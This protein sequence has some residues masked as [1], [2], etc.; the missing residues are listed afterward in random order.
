MADT[1]RNRTTIEEIFKD[2]ISGD[3][4]PQDLR[5]YVATIYDYGRPV[6]LQD[7]KL[8]SEEFWDDA[9]G[10]A[11]AKQ[12]GGAGGTALGPRQTIVLPQAPS[13]QDLKFASPITVGLNDRLIGVGAGFGTF[14]DFSSLDAAELG[15]IR[16]SAD[17]SNFIHGIVLK[18]F[19]IRNMPDGVAGIYLDKKLAENAVFDLIAIAGNGASGTSDGF[20]ITAS[21]VG[22]TPFKMG[23]IAFFACRYGLNIQTLTSK[24]VA[25]FNQISG[26]NNRWLVRARGGGLGGALTIET[27]KCEMGGNNDATDSA[28]EG[29]V[30]LEDMFKTEIGGMHVEVVGTGRTPSVHA[31]VEN[32]RTSIDKSSILIMP[33]FGAT[34]QNEYPFGY[35][36][37]HPTNGLIR[38]FNVEECNNFMYAED[39]HLNAGFM[40]EAR[41]FGITDLDENL[42]YHEDFMEAGTFSDSWLVV[43]GS[44]AQATVARVANRRQ[45]VI[46]MTAGN[47]AAGTVSAN[48]IAATWHQKIW[49]QSTRLDARLHLDTLQGA[50]FVG[51]TDV[52]ATASSFVM[53][54]E[55]SANN[56][57]AHPDITDCTGFLFDQRAC[58]SAQ[59]H[60]VGVRD[61]TIANAGSAIAV[62]ASVAYSSASAVNG[63][64]ANTFQTLS[65]TGDTSAQFFIDNR[66]VGNGKFG[67]ATLWTPS[68]VRMSWGASSPATEVD[69][70][71]MKSGREGG[72]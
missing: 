16:F 20:V 9:M 6:F 14:L 48:I 69:Y 51:F 24:I 27:I 22:S 30:W 39:D 8:D 66:K 7:Y 70:L 33:F 3:I 71:R 41:T 12:T 62:T 44:D 65:V 38:Q 58:A 23:S 36:E 59:W 28:I 50:Q 60:L 11:Q 56:L 46:R 18:S 64:V 37:V 4:S 53:P 45:G 2:N 57:S 35:R 49:G 21:A 68:V 52:L 40:K 43:S 67:N 25:A 72:I 31:M 1:P 32:R 17:A 34:E 5:D 19:T 47:A 29:A 13:G 54:M 42:I 15:C 61:G 26:D 10:R 63:P 55:L